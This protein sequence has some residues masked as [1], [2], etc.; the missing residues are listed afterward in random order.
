MTTNLVPYTTQDRART[1]A[2]ARRTWLAAQLRE[3]SSERGP[4]WRVEERPPEGSS[5]DRRSLDDSP[6]EQLGQLARLKWQMNSLPCLLLERLTDLVLADTYDQGDK[7]SSSP[8]AV[9]LQPL[10][11]GVHRNL[12][13]WRAVICSHDERRIAEQVRKYA[14]W[15][16]IGVDLEEPATV[17]F[18]GRCTADY[19]GF[20]GLVGGLL[21]GDDLYALTCHHVVTANCGSL[22]PLPTLGQVPPTISTSVPDAVLLRS[23]TPCF[24]VPSQDARPYALATNPLI[25]HI[26]LKRLPV[27]Q[28]HPEASVR[29][30]G[31]VKATVST[32]T[33]GDKVVRGPLVEIIPDRKSYLFGLLK[34]PLGAKHFSSPGD[35]GGWVIDTGT[36]SWLGVV[37]A[38][39]DR[40][41]TYATNASFLL[42]YFR[43]LLGSQAE[44][45]PT[46]W[47]TS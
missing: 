1:R 6:F 39:D 30:A 47:A 23:G 29:I 40:G 34:L 31:V 2:M 8:F 33:V 10:P 22:A 25:E 28:N 19:G 35:S 16:G 3:S 14:D 44:L 13:P 36:R 18:T 38:G 17:R 7:S 43:K 26:M 42:E 4:Q 21:E 20:A 46:S 24:H 37:T 5:T 41:S 15:L 27:S 9:K 32:T 45:L 11:I 12:F